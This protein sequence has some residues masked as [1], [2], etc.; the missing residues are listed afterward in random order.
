MDKQIYS[1]YSEL[2]FEEFQKFS[3]PYELHDIA[4]RCLFTVQQWIV[5]SSLCSEATALMLFWHNS[6]TDFLDYGW[7]KK[8]GSRIEDFD[9]IRTII[10]NFEKGFYLKTDIE[11]DPSEAI[12]KVEFIPEVV[13][14]ASKGEEPYIYID[15]KEV[16]SWFGDYL[17]SKIYHCDTTM[18]LYNIVVS[19]KQRDIDVYEKLLDHPLCDKAIALII[20]WLFVKYS[21]SSLYAEQWLTIKPILEKIVYRLENNEYQEILAYDPNKEVKPIKW[22]IPNYMFKK[23]GR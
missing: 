1:D 6:P 12:S 17:D 5:E 4:S 8:T 3:T 11:Y 7:N 19:L 18:E 9:L 10:N 22:K 2:T 21:N 14:Q 16:H 13:L 23:I 15:K 20:Y